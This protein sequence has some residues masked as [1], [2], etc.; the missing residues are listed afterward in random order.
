M[1]LILELEE[2]P[3]LGHAGTCS[4][5]PNRLRLTETTIDLMEGRVSPSAPLSFENL[6]CQ[7][8]HKQYSSTSLLI[9][10][11]PSGPQTERNNSSSG[12][13]Y[14]ATI[15]NNIVL[16]SHVHLWQHR[17]IMMFVLY[18]QLSVLRGFKC[19]VRS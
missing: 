5:F 8:A 3:R 18:L 14:C 4:R 15:G 16:Q 13:R 9:S 1:S 7:H 10:N 2:T 17:S 19:D 6:T 11:L 12:G